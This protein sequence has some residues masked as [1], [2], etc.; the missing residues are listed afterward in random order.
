MLSSF[1]STLL[2]IA[3]ITFISIISSRVYHDHYKD[4][5]FGRRDVYMNSNIILWY[6]VAVCSKCI[7][8]KLL[9]VM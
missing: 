8:P 7:A 1:Y 2:F 4:R 3:I 6:Y 5:L 9:C